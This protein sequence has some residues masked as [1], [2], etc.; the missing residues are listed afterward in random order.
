[1]W[2]SPS[3]LSDPSVRPSALYAHMHE[4]TFYSTTT[5][6]YVQYSLYHSHALKK[7]VVVMEATDG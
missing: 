1:M 5:V 3:L 2:A 7:E 4:H 6:Y